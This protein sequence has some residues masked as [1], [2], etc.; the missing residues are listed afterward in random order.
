MKRWMSSPVAWAALVAA[1]ILAAWAGSPDTPSLAELAGTGPL[2]AGALLTC[3]ACVGAAALALSGGGGAI[4][5]ALLPW[6]A[7]TKAM[8]C[9]AA[10]YSAFT[11]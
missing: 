7:T 9:V 2:L 1:S 3:G 10:C 4:L 8:A 5:A 6:S 11:L